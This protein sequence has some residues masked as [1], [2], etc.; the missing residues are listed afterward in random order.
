M[1]QASRLVEAF[2]LANR[3]QT[4]C[5]PYQLRFVSANGGLLQSSSGVQIATDALDDE[6]SQRVHAFFHLHGE[7]ALIAWNETLLRR[8]RDVHARARWLA[9]GMKF[10][11]IAASKWA[12]ARDDAAS[13]PVVASLVSTAKD[14]GPPNEAVDVLS[15]ALD[16]FR[17]DLGEVAADDIARLVARPIDERFVQS[18]W[19][20]RELS[21]T[22]SIR[23]SMQQLRA[24]S[25]SRISIAS[26][27]QAV[28]MSER[29]FLRRFK[30]EVGVTPTEFVLH[31][32]LE[33]ACHMLVHTSLPADK[34]AR[35]IGLG[36]GERLAKLFRQRL[37]MSPTE[38]RA[39]ERNRISKVG[40][41]LAYA[42]QMPQSYGLAR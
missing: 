39:R 42:P 4:V 15:A 28:A 2:N 32:R 23:T 6:H 34:V 13:G 22:P 19:A 41:E 21:A 30:K 8:L 27:A 25:T 20:I 31:V 9:D 37:A 10:T 11:A 5:G 16:M 33:R 18:M 36:S 40:A 38:F 24:Q 35:R 26:T 14:A 7:H 12:A 3:L 29:N 17:H 1:A